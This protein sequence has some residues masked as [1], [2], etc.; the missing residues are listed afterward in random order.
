MIKR[1]RKMLDEPN[2]SDKTL[3]LSV[4]DLICRA[5]GSNTTNAVNFKLIQT[6]MLILARQLRLLEQDVEIKFDDMGFDFDAGSPYYESDDEYSVD[7][8][9]NYTDDEPHSRRSSPLPE[10]RGGRGAVKEGSKKRAEK[11]REEKG[12]IKDGSDKGT[13]KDRREK[14]E[15]GERVDK[16]EKGENKKRLYKDRK[17][18]SKDRES[19]SPDR[20]TNEDYD[21]TKERDG[22]GMRRGGRRKRGEDDKVESG[23]RDGY[24]R[25]RGGPSK[26][27]V[28]VEDEGGELDRYGRRHDGRHDGRSRRSEDDEEESGKSV[29]HGR[30]RD[31]KKRGGED[32]EGL[33]GERDGQGR[34]QG[35]RKRKPEDDRQEGE[36][37]DGRDRAQGGRKTRSEDDGQEGGERDGLGRRVGG[38]R[39]GGEDDGDEAD[40]RE[41]RRHEQSKDRVREDRTHGERRGDYDR[42]DRGQR[43]GVGREG[44]RTSITVTEGPRTGG[45]GGTVLIA[46][47]E[48]TPQGGRVARVGSIEVVTASQFA[49]LARAVKQLEKA[50]GPLPVPELP[51][52]EQLREDVLKG[53]ASLSDTMEAVQL[54]ARV[55]AAEEGL[56]RMAGLLTQLTAAGALPMDFASRIGDLH[57]ELKKSQAQAGL[58]RRGFPFG[59]RPGPRTVPTRIAEDDEYDESETG[60][61]G[62]DS[63]R[64]EGVKLEAGGPGGGAV[65]LSYDNMPVTHND[66][67]VMLEQMKAALSKEIQAMTARANH[68]A[69][70]ASS[71]SRTVSEKLGIALAIDE[72]ISSLFSQTADYAEQLSGFDTGLASQM[73]SFQEQ[74]EVMR[75]DLRGGIELLNSANNN[76]ETAAVL[77]LTER[78]E[79]LTIELAGTVHLHNNLTLVEQQIS[80]EQKN[81]MECIEMLREQKADREE[82]IDCLRDKV[83]VAD[84]TGLLN[85]TDFAQARFEIEK[86]IEKSYSK[87]QKQDERWQLVMK[88]LTRITD[89]KAELVSLIAFKHRAEKELNMIREELHH[90]ETLLGEPKAALLMRKLAVNAA[91]G[92]C[93]TP[94]MMVPTDATY[95]KPATLPG[96][97][98]APVGAEDP[99]QVDVK[100]RPADTRRH[101]CHRWVG[102]SH[103]LVSG[104]VAH[105][106]AAQ[107]HP[108]PISTKKYEAYGT[109][110]KLYMMEEESQPCEE[111]NKGSAGDA[112]GLHPCPSPTG[113]GDR[114][115]ELVGSN[116]GPP[117]PRSDHA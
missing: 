20:G 85:E 107:S 71:T 27:G 23:E 74:M 50:T 115:L 32:N 40:Q 58:E 30:R 28:D 25:R 5:F 68:S 75:S 53:R 6:V 72:R 8:Y 47:R 105:Q 113:S 73:A 62:P 100:L 84:L 80:D 57:T 109:D 4:E 59:D 44:S 18:G 61:A 13:K 49:L 117:S 36:E 92:A 90:L 43:H 112:D 76:A 1:Y 65:P 46:Q 97:R 77:E 51:D 95:G 48:P 16:S 3:L 110:G 38:R 33:S 79:T 52:N 87:F 91:C 94:A 70:I 2:M 29:G 67:Q 19:S 103:T 41:D 99:C 78:Y 17:R 93:L 22:R 7:Y 56:S 88:D 104:H 82:V 86:R 45:G 102:G 83:D 111:C 64:A 14:K 60:S 42:D 34:R 81:L 108:E 31:G 114:A 12:E 66:M 101:I 106:K 63:K 11:E 21:E 35:G 15:K 9:D 24:G 10:K 26:R 54:N 39:R 89:H 69:D 37:R 55:Q 116:H 98:P 96:L